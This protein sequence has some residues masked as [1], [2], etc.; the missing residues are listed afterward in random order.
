MTITTWTEHISLKHD[1]VLINRAGAFANSFEKGYNHTYMVL[2][3]G[4]IHA[5]SLGLTCHM[6]TPNFLHE[7]SQDHSAI[8]E[9]NVEPWC[10]LTSS[11]ESIGD[12]YIYTAAISKEDMIQ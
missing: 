12:I 6:L 7:L 9:C 5:K 10:W 4:T 8:V 3:L 1:N 2:G 11:S